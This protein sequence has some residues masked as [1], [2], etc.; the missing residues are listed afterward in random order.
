MSFAKLATGFLS[1]V[2]S[3]GSSL[4]LLVLG[5]QFLTPAEFGAYALATLTLALINVFLYSGAYEHLLKTQ[6]VGADGP[7]V[8]SVKLF[9]AVLSAILLLSVGRVLLGFDDLAQLGFLLQIFAVVPL[10][11]CTSAWREAAYLRVPSH[12]PR[13]FQLTLFRDGVAL[14]LAIAWLIAGWGLWALVLHRVTLALIGA[15][16]FGWVERPLPLPDWR[17]SQVGQLLR[18][19]SALTGSRLLSFFGNN[20]VDMVVGVFL[21]PAAVGLYRMASRMAIALYDVIAQP[22]VKYAWVHMASERR[23]GRTGRD[24]L[25]RSQAASLLLMGLAMGY[26][27]GGKEFLVPLL[28]G[29]HWQAAIPLLPWMAAAA[30]GRAFGIFVEPVLSLEGHAGKLFQLRLVTTVLAVGLVAAGAAWG[31]TDGAATM[32][33]AGAVL[34]AGL[35]WWGLW[36]WTTVPMSVLAEGLLL[37]ALS[38]GLAWLVTWG[39][40]QAP[41]PALQHLGLSVVALG[42][43]GGPLA[44]ACLR[45]YRPQRLKTP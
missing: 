27:S 5:A 31:H 16:L 41:V 2:I 12:L 10:M 44:W 17:L 7:T 26:I 15:L 23:Q 19:T 28:L 21:S 1:R 42:L 9:Y 22:L 33:L 35:F 32:R 39:V 40:Q 18:K 4:I 45:K 6:D 38:F 3:Q 36:R 8:L 14:L 34:G 11:S 37:A 29:A 24:V 20:G 43:C 30:L 13:Y 25:R